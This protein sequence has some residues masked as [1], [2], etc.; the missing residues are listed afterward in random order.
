LITLLLT[1]AFMQST[2]WKPVDM[3]TQ[4]CGPTA[5][6]HAMDLKENGKFVV[7]H[8]KGEFDIVFDGECHDNDKEFVCTPTVTKLGVSTCTET[9]RKV[10]KP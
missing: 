3:G 8:Q 9:G 7:N 5:H 2:P 1:L 6:R 10:L 4:D